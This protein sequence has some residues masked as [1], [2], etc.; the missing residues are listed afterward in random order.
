M[1]SDD[2]EGDSAREEACDVTSLEPAPTRSR[3]LLWPSGML[4]LD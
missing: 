2:A 1:G 3:V 4:E